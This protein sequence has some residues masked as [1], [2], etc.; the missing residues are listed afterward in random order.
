[1]TGAQWDQT[2]DGKTLLQVV[3]ERATARKLRLF[4]VNCYRELER[5][6]VEP[7]WKALDLAERL[8][9]GLA[10]N[11]ERKYALNSERAHRLQRKG[12]P[13][14]VD[15]TPVLL[16]NAVQAA[17]VGLTVVSE[18]LGV[19]QRRYWTGVALVREIFGN[20]F[21]L[22]TVNPTWLRWNGGTI[23]KI[24]AGIYG[25]RAFDRLPI[26]ADA[27]LDAGCDDEAIL[28]HCRGDGP[29]VRGCWVI[30]LILGKS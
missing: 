5:L 10:T 14:S 20:P 17:Y 3:S 29:H 7:G 26:L 4:A 2:K 21:R 22:V 1:M 9:D 6:S 19:A 18:A 24:A 8:A 15:V 27:L 28:A 12:L 16:A 23:P 11:K 13:V 30:D 25:E